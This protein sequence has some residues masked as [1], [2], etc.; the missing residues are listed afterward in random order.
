M[1]YFALDL[2]ISDGDGLVE[3][4]GIVEE[5]AVVGFMVWKFGII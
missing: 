3:L 4:G 1:V 2:G 5:L